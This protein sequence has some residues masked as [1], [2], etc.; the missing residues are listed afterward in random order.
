MLVIGG[1][2]TGNDCVGTSIRQG[3]VA[4]TQLEMM[5]KLPETRVANNPWPEWP[6]VLKTDYGQQEAIA[7][8]GHDPRIYETTVKEIVKNKDGQVCAAKCVKLAWEKDPE[9][10][11]MNMKEIPDSEY[12]IECDLI[13]IAAG[14]LGTQKYVAD[15]FGVK[16]NERTNVAADQENYATSVERVYAAGDVR[17]GQSLVVWAIREGREVARAVDESLMGY[18]YLSVQ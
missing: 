10:G 7:K 12:T 11:R 3:A 16:L 5:P 13:L 14:F 8:F 4:V 6:R 17:R 15:A 1:G 2:D 18:S 9:T